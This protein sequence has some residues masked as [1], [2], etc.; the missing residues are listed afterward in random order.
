LNLAIHSYTFR[1]N[2]KVFENSTFE[3]LVIKQEEA[4]GTYYYYLY[5]YDRIN[6]SEDEFPYVVSRMLLSEAVINS[7]NLDAFLQN[8]VPPI[9]C[10][11]W[12]VSPR[13]F[14][15]YLY[16]E[17]G[18]ISSDSANNSSGSNDNNGSENASDT[19]NSSNEN[20]SSDTGNTSDTTNPN[21]SGNTGNT[22]PSGGHPASGGTSPTGNY[23]G[24]GVQSTNDFHGGIPAFLDEIPQI[25]DSLENC[26]G[27]TNTNIGS[28]VFNQ[29]ENATQLNTYLQNNNCSLEAQNFAIQAIEA[30]MED[31]NLSFGE[32]KHI[33]ENEQ[34]YKDRMSIE[35]LNIYNSLNRFKQLRYLQSAYNAETMM[36]NLYPID[37]DNPCNAYNGQGDA[38]RH[39]LWNA[40]ATVRIG[41]NL[42]QQLTTAHENHPAPNNYPISLYNKE[43]QMDLYNNARGREL[44]NTSGLIIDAVVSAKENGNLRYLSNLD[45]NNCRATSESILIPTN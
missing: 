8:S 43:K 1:L 19:D 36:N 17:E 22:N 16:C 24:G 40:L 44:A 9:D 32:Y 29:T 45:S 28:F 23:E 21:N 31:E 26:L 7:N 38:F 39:A 3:N 34:N 18:C 14:E 25:T 20:S 15:P 10:C 6:N 13:D 42:T 37:I 5:R 12:I 35:E 27:S 4:N 33:V 2:T 30:L 11:Y 41:E